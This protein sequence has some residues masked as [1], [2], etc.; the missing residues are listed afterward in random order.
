MTTKV[1]YDFTTAR[2]SDEDPQNV[3]LQELFHQLGAVLNPA[4]NSCASHSKDC[5]GHTVQFFDMMNRTYPRV[6][7]LEDCEDEAP[8]G[9]VDCG[10][11]DYYSTLCAL[12]KSQCAGPNGTKGAGVYLAGAF[13]IAE[14]STWL[15]PISPKVDDVSC[16]G[17][18]TSQARNGDESH[19]HMLLYTYNDQ[20]H[21][22]DGYD[23]VE[24]KQ[25]DDYL[26]GGDGKDTLHGNANADQLW[27][28][29]GNDSIHGGLGG[30]VLRGHA[31]ND[32]LVGGDGDDYFYDGRGGLDTADGGLGIDTLYK[33]ATDGL[34]ST[35]VS[36]EVV[37][38]STSYC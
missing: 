17:A 1:A 3:A 10:K 31:G 32:E 23:Y 25:G 4:P 14:H 2:T 12:D 27:G 18:A 7:S 35:P 15:G 28:G 13:N 29:P 26:C 22:L 8:L 21:L 33:C 34:A 37:Y 11:E 30:D 36:V 5:G 24:G 20:V 16:A 38:S 19:D 9:T 6:P